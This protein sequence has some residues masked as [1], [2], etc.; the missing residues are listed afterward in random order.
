M[1]HKLRNKP[2]A[3]ENIGAGFFVFGRCL[4]TG[5]VHPSP[6]PFEHADVDAAKREAQRLALLEPGKPFEVYARASAAVVFDGAAEQSE[7]A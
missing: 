1:S 4:K 5:R 7:A 2:R 3:A 6:Y